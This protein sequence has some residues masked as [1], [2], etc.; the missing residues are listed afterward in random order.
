MTVFV[1]RASAVLA[2]VIVAFWTPRTAWGQT[3]LRVDRSAGISD[4]GASWASPIRFLRTAIDNAVILGGNVQIWVRAN[5]YRPDEYVLFANGDGDTAK[6]F[7]LNNNITIY[8]GFNGT[9]TLLSQR[10]AAVNITYLSGDLDIDDTANW[11][12]RADNSLHVVTASGVNATAVLDGFT[13][14]G[15]HAGSPGGGALYCSAA[16]SPV[17]TN[18]IFTDNET[19]AVGGGAVRISGGSPSFSACAFTANRATSGV[20]GA[21]HIDSSATVTMAGCAFTS[22][23]ALS[24]GALNVASSSSL[25]AISC[26]FTTNTA[27][28]GNGGAVATGSASTFRSCTFTQNVADGDGGGAGAGSTTTFVLCTFVGNAAGDEGGGLHGGQSCLSCRFLGN[29][30]AVRGGGVRDNPSLTNCLFSGNTSVRG[31]AVQIGSGNASVINCTFSFNSSTEADPLNGKG[32]LQYNGSQTLTVTNCIFF[33]NTSAGAETEAAQI[34]LGDNGTL[35]LNYSFVQGLTGTFGGIGNTGG[36]AGDDPRFVWPAGPDQ[37]VGTLDDDCSLFPFSSC[38]DSAD[39]TALPTDSLDVDGD[40]NIFEQLP[41]DLAGNTRRVDDPHVVNSGVG[42]APGLDRGAYEQHFSIRRWTGGPG[43]TFSNSSKWHPGAPGITDPAAFSNSATVSF[44]QNATIGML[45]IASGEVRLNVGAFNF[46]TTNAPTG[47]NV[48]IGPFKNQPAALIFA[49][50]TGQFIT[51]LVDIDQWGT[52]R[53]T[54]VFDCN[55]INNGGTLDPGD[56]A[57][58]SPGTLT[59]TGNYSQ[60]LYKSD[61]PGDN[62]RGTL[63]IGV[64]GDQPGEHDLLDVQGFANLAGTLRIVTSSEFNPPDDLNIEILHADGGFSVGD[65]TFDIAVMPGLPDGRFY[66]VSY[67]ESGGVYL[68]VLDLGG[69]LG[70]DA[71]NNTAGTFLTAVD[72]GDLNNDTLPDIAVATSD[73]FVIL[74]FNGGNDFNGDWLGFTSSLQLSSGGASPAG[75]VIADFDPLNANGLDVAVTNSGSDNVVV[76]SRPDTVNWTQAATVNL[77][78]GDVPLGICAA[79]FDGNGST[80]LCTAD[81]GSNNFSMLN[82]TSGVSIS[83]GAGTRTSTEDAPASVDPWDPDNPKSAASVVVANSSSNSVTFHPNNGNGT[84]SP[85]TSYSVGAGPG[86]VGTGDFNGDGTEDIVSVNRADGTL[87]FLLNTGGTV[88]SL[89]SAA[90]VGSD[91]TSLVI[92]DVNNDGAI[93]I[94]VTAVN[95]LAERVV[96]LLQNSTQ[97]GE[98]TVT[99]VEP[100]SLTTAQPPSAI[101]S[102]DVD[103]DGFEDIIAV[104]DSGTEIADNITVRLNVF[105]ACTADYNRDGFVTGEDFDEYVLLFELGDPQADTN[106]DGFV[107]G[108]D[109]D[110]FVQHFVD[111]C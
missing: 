91:P 43:G 69:D 89:S 79:D 19:S 24:A 87:S 29:S 108:E 111:G 40:S 110:L 26:T 6:S 76:L 59:L 66:K 17:I 35:A 100:V 62:S 56:P 9:E 46:D 1:T 52:L 58:D 93:D 83:F 104:S 22:N 55:Y 75:L 5:T 2:A 7:A 67:V 97:P 80:D 63:V 61:A 77:V 72:A 42:G 47:H 38:I 39:N 25:S 49:P 57:D 27:S 53:G 70:F 85:S 41:L 90:T 45:T 4:T 20:G 32:V 103:Q 18:C 88:F 98:F 11:G 30:A 10:N 84:F 106:H 86:T 12:A 109:F 65:P 82:N 33:R 31:G 13:I 54:G 94:A 44:S 34:K 51:E 21:A 16:A 78:A 99:F 81:S 15:G 71:R 107:T 95:D 28:T 101:T 73:G 48:L 74:L 3:I 102:A 14:K 64:A 92:A 50:T 36:L 105:R 37:A 96:Q 60:Y 23:T 8:G 68:S